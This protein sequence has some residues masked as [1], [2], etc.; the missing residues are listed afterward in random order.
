MPYFT[1]I[2][3]LTRHL[4]EQEMYNIFNFKEGFFVS[5]ILDLPKTFLALFIT[6]FITAVVN[7]LQYVPIKYEKL[8]NEALKT[9]DKKNIKA[10]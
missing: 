2:A 4:I 6:I 3:T 1:Q 8:L 10:A 5:F 7:L 9:K